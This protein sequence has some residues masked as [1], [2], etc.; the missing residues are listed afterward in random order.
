MKNKADSQNEQFSFNS[1]ECIMNSRTNKENIFSLIEGH[2]Q[3]QQPILRN[4]CCFCNKTR[5]CIQHLIT[6]FHCTSEM[7]CPGVSESV[8][9]PLPPQRVRSGDSA[10]VIL[11]TVSAR[12]AFLA[13]QLLCFS[14][15]CFDCLRLPDWFHPCLVNL[16]FLVYSIPF[17]CQFVVLPPEFSMVISPQLFPA[18]LVT[19]DRDP[20]HPP[21]SPF[22]ICFPSL[23]DFCFDL[24]P[25][26]LTSSKPLSFS[27]EVPLN[28]TSFPG[29]ACCLLRS[30][31]AKLNN[32]WCL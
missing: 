5:N 10:T 22:S 17:L 2:W 14:Y 26:P 27:I 32:S 12:P 7:K 31:V 3:A 29:C 15:N 13:V 9:A 18:L 28:W 21:L 19:L 6:Q 11:E 1:N 20:P 30:M 24:H 25:P 16:S 4:L 8:F 23:A